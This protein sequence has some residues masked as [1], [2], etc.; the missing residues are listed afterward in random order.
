MVGADS[1]LYLGGGFTQVGGVSRPYVAAVDRP[2]GSVLAWNPA[3]NGEVRALARAD[4]V[5]YIGGLFTVLGATPRQDLG[6][7]DRAS[8]AATS[9]NPR[10]DGPLSTT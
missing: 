8:G 5:I 4:S 10:P 7:V 6:A 1:I 2:S 9:W 3:S